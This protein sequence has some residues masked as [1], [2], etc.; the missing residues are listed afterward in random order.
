[1]DSRAD[2]DIERLLRHAA[3]GDT[4]ALGRL[5]GRYRNYLKLLAR[6]QIDRR[7][8]GKVDPSD[9]V[10]DA[11]LYVHS[12]FA[13]FRGTTEAELLG[14]LRRVLT[15]KLKDSVR[16]FCQTQRRDVALERP[17]GEEVDQTSRI[18]QAL[19]SPESSP[20]QKASRRERAALVADAVAQLPE[21]Y[22][23]VIIMRHMEELPFQEI[24][25]RMGRS[26]DAVKKLWVRALT[27]LRRS[28]GGTKDDSAS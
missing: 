24:A 8:R 7:L 3:A 26:E 17:I 12:A 16:H 22:R 19:A 28:L 11:F 10:Q 9:V 27:A 13:D 1:M 21:S 6:V 23:E 2:S 5:L 25:Q 4:Q 14:W 15:S 18:I 20:S